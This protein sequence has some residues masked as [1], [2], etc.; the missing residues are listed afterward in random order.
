[1]SDQQT[2]A[3]RQTYTSV[4]FLSPYMLDDRYA[5]AL[6]ISEDHL[7]KIDFYIYFSYC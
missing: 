4:I 3:I 5:P 7:I 6:N 2:L 1:M